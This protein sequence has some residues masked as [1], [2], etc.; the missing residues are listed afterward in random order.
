MKQSGRRYKK[1]KNVQTTVK[2]DTNIKARETMIQ[3]YLAKKLKD[4]SVKV[5]KTVKQR[6]HNNDYEMTGDVK[7]VSGNIQGH[8][9][10]DEEDNSTESDTDADSDCERLHDVEQESMNVQ[11]DSESL[12][13]SLRVKVSCKLSDSSPSKGTDLPSDGSKNSPKKGVKLEVLQHMFS[14]RTSESMGESGSEEEEA[15]IASSIQISVR[16]KQCSTN[17]KIKAKLA[18]SSDEN[19]ESEE[20]ESSSDESQI[21]KCSSKPGIVSTHKMNSGIMGVKKIN[22]E[23]LESKSKM[24]KLP[25]LPIVVVILMLKRWMIHHLMTAAAVRKRSKEVGE[26]G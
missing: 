2:V 9:A 14:S 10:D 6:K 11:T 22:L 13:K 17:N 24:K 5:N 19:S 4:D 1:K 21:A 25:F 7:V 26:R 18:N 16:N 23:D 15:K 8:L 20:F 3:A 12:S